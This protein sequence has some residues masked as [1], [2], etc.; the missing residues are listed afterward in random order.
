M[1]ATSTLKAKILRRDERVGVL[2]VAGDEAVVATASATVLDPAR[3]LEAVARPVSTARAILGATKF[4][5]DN[6]CEL[7]GA[8]VAALQ[9]KL[10]DPILPPH[11]VLIGMVPQS[12][13]V[14][15]SDAVVEESGWGGAAASP[16]AP[17]HAPGDAPAHDDDATVPV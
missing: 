4:T 10:G 2:A 15:E 13:A 12:V 14:L 6:A 8:V 11:R 1:T 17:G 3:P 5:A 16:R 7:T 9:G